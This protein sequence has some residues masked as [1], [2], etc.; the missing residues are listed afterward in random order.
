MQSRVTGVCDMYHLTVKGRQIGAGK[1][2]VCVPVTEPDVEGVLREMEFL[3]ASP[4]EMVE[5]RVD[6]FAEFSDCNRV[7]EVLSKAA[8]I[9]RDKIFLFTFRTKKQGGV[10]DA[11]LE[12]V[13]DLQ[14]LAAESGC[15]D[16][17]DMEFFEERRPPARVR[18]L[19]KKHI[20]V[21]ASH[22]DFEETPQPDVMMMLLERMCAGGAD[23]VKLA[24]MP[25][26]KR[27]VL[28]LLD[29]TEEFHATHPALPV[30]TM[31][32]GT[33]GAISRLCGEVFGSCVT[34]GVHEKA[35]A[36]GQIEMNCL[37]QTL[38]VIHESCG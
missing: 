34:F 36:P 33:C 3:A 17:V 35:S 2:C 24:V 21:I 9:L 28:R 12:M 32:M 19:K 10:S 31:S 25:Y 23:I 5:W 30:I 13:H 26:D 16:F 38:D 14:D 15:V 27:D 37:M 7:R 1:P 22:H 6:A 20:G 4:V 18:D 11:P 29:V 8:G